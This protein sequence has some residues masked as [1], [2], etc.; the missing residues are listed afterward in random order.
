MKIVL[1]NVPWSPIGFPSVALGL[2]KSLTLKEF[3]DAD[4]DVVYGNLDFVDWI[5]ARRPDFNYEDYRY[6]D[7][8][9]CYI[10]TGDWVFS[11]ALYHAPQWKVE[12][13]LAEF[14]AQEKAEADKSLAHGTKEESRTQITLWLHEHV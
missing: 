13:F 4:V 1:T 14:G 12:E 5:V 11:S 8:E 7:L 10:G 3:P 9:S 2:L 6:Y